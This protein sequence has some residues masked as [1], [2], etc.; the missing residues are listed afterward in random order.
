MACR[1]SAAGEV[2]GVGAGITDRR[3]AILSRAPERA[4]P[5]MPITS[6]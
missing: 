5:I 2:V 1:L 3:S 6:R 4:R